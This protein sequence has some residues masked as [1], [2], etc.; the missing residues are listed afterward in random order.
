VASRIFAEEDE[1]STFS[2]GNLVPPTP[3]GQA[4]NQGP[5]PAD[6]PFFEEHLRQPSTDR[7][8][9]CD[10]DVGLEA[11]EYFA[12]LVAQSATEM[13]TQLPDREQSPA[14]SMPGSA[15]LPVDANRTPRRRWRVG[16]SQ[17]APR[18]H[19]G[20]AAASRSVVVLM[21]TAVLAGAA[22]ALI[23]VS[24][25][26]QPAAVQSHGTDSQLASMLSVDRNPFK[27]KVDSSSRRVKPAAR[28]RHAARPRRTRAAVR[29]RAAVN[30]LRR[31]STSASA[32]SAPPANVSQSAGSSSSGSATG[33]PATSSTASSEPPPQT[34]SGQ[35]ASSNTPPAF[36]ATGTLAPGHSSIG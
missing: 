1:I 23:V 14:V 5:S 27:L 21:S 20:H 4:A 10:A 33:A 7:E 13:A 22:L 32:T 31:T 16:R 12:Q 36:G 2:Q 18:R 25:G 19:R 3:P 17:S 8:L 30:R 34:S 26:H 15:H 9:T 28:L 11:D 29:S 35:A 24:L 6:D